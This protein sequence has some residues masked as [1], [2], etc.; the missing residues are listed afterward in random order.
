M[1]ALSFTYPQPSS[2]Q[3]SEPFSKQ[4]NLLITAGYQRDKWIPNQTAFN[5]SSEPNISE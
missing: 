2:T 1:L 5:N 3:K 4:K